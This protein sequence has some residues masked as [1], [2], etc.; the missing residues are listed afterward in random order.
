MKVETVVVGPIQTNCYLISDDDD[1]IVVD[2][3]DELENIMRCL[4]GRTPSA[5]VCTHWHW[6]HVSALSGLQTKTGAP[7]L[8]STADAPKICVERMDGHDV[9]RGFGAP[10]VDRELSEGDEVRVGGAVFSVIETPGHTPGCIC[11][12]DVEH[13]VL[14]AGDTLF[15]GGRYG[16]TDFEDGS[17]ADICASMS[18]KLSTLP[19]ETAILCGHGPASDM[20]IERKLNPYL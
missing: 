15:A 1:L 14:V 12:H 8:A 4:D 6:D 10:H 7:V 2:P 3:G 11:L 5:I 18:N 16:R 9:S 17:F 19:D 13:G 20:A